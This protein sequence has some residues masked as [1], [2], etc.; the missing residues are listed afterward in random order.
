MRIWLIIAALVSGWAL[1]FH[2]EVIEELLASIVM[3][4][5]FTLPFGAIFLVAGFLPY[6][7]IVAGIIAFLS[8]V[9]E[10]VR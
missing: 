3:L 10:A 4:G 5:A 1:C 6:L 8:I 2:S 9:W 7:L